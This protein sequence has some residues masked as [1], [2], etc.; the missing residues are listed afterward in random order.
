MTAAPSGAL[1][2]H[3][4]QFGMAIL[5]AEGPGV[6]EPQGRQQ[7]QRGGVG[8]PVRHREADQHVVGRILGVLD[9]HVEV[10]VLVEDARVEQLIL[11]L[12]LSALAVDLDQLLVGK[13]RL[14]ILV[15]ALEVR[16]GRRGI[17]VEV[18]FLQVLAVVA[19]GAGQAEG[20]LLED[21]IAL[22]PEREREAE[23]L[24]VVRDAH[25]PVLSPAVNPRTRVVVGKIIPG[26]AGRAVILAH[27]APLAFA[28]VRA[29]PPPVSFARAFI[30]QSLL[31]RVHRLSGVPGGRRERPDP[32]GRANKGV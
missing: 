23:P 12:V 20:A 24:V 16:V 4:H 15:E 10:A 3:E 18:I 19:L 26:L 9:L 22:V 11:Q 13:R 32:A 5:A 1:P 2:G 17:D 30:F 21:R 14:R 29:P 7:V 25:Q 31:F 28:Q 6:A 27:R 8:T